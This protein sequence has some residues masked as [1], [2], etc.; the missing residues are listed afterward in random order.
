MYEWIDTLSETHLASDVKHVCVRV[1][2][3]KKDSRRTIEVVLYQRHRK[4]ILQ[5]Y[6]KIKKHTLK[7][8][9]WTKIPDI[10]T[11][12]YIYFYIGD[13]LYQ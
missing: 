8:I 6:T 7:L 5:M 9:T 13:T 12:I 4:I 2:E 1:V 10:K 3:R 11:L